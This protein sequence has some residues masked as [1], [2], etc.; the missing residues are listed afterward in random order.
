MS[1][2]SIALRPWENFIHISAQNISPKKY[3]DLVVML[4]LKHVIVGFGSRRKNEVFERLV[5][6]SGNKKYKGTEFIFQ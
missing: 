1:V 5:L 3:K 4:T 2:L 6:R